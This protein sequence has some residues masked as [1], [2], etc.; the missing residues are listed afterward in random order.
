MT[1][2]L[3]GAPG[4]MVRLTL[5]RPGREKTIELSLVRA[6]LDARS[7]R[8][9]VEGGDVGYIRIAQFDGQT[10]DQL[11]QAIAD[12]ASQVPADQL[13][14]YVLDLRNDPGGPLD[15]AV[16]VADDFLDAGEIVAIRGRTAEETKHIRAT[17]GDLAKGKSLVV[18]I[19]AGSAATSEVVA[20]ALQ[21]AHRA[22][23]VGTRSFGQGS[24]GTLIALGPDNGA[25]HLTTGHYVTPAG[26]TIESKGISPDVEAAQDLPDDLKPSAKADAKDANLQSYIPPDP[27]ADKALNVAYDMLRHPKAAATVP[28]AKN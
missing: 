27:K 1:E 23:L 2:R 10:A 22:T 21:D 3:R 4:T 24:V 20:G 14:G 8:A 9:H 7:V 11:K 12:I 5:V 19:N 18:L 26:H 28:P 16:P 25:I 6:K 13:K 15:D 17:T